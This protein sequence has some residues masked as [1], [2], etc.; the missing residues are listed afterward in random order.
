V[1]SE[2][3]TFLDRLSLAPYNE[4]E[5]IKAQARAY[6]RRHGHNPKVN[7]A[8]QIERTRTNFA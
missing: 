2:G 3:F 4:G 5:D 8:D 1:T 7:C 6:R